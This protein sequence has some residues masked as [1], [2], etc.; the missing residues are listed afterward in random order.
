[1]SLAL[2]THASRCQQGA[3]PGTFEHGG[4]V[5]IS[6]TRGAMILIS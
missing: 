1:M 4:S 6:I 3:S 5:E 2:C